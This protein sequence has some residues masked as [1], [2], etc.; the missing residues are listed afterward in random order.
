M[1]FARTLIHPLFSTLQHGTLKIVDPYGQ[2]TVGKHEK[3]PYAEL[4]VHSPAFYHKVLLGGSIG[5]GEAYEEGYWDSPNLVELLTLL[6][7]NQHTLSSAYPVLRLAKKLGDIRQHR[8][9]KNTRPNSKKNIQAH[10]DLSNAFYQTFLDESMTYSAGIFLH[11]DD[12]LYQAQLNKIHRLIEQVDLQSSHHLLEIGSGWGSFAIE[13]VRQTGCRVTTITL[14]EEQL[15]LAQARV[16]KAG[17]SDH[18]EVK[19]CDYRDVPGTFD[20][21]VSIEMLEAVGHEF[22]ETYFQC[23]ARHLKPGGK[24]GL[25]VITIPHERYDAYRTS[26]DWIRKHIFPGGHLPSLEILRKVSARQGLNI[27]NTKDIGLDYARTLHLWREQFV[28]N[29]ATITSLGFGE[30]FQRKWVYYLAYCEAGFTT[31]LLHDYQVVLTR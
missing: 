5:F 21:I 7:R 30:P 18:I 10:Y 6:A 13:A 16:Q 29:Q 4:L 17:L 2:R 14:S 26:V 25:Q 20:R 12:S 27:I 3:E 1:S 11:P 24:L 9:R 22:L 19:L 15:V 31:Q 8:L 28:R 23:C